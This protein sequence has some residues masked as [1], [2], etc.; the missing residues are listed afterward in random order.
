M[1]NKVVAIFARFLIDVVELPP[2]KLWQK[3]FIIE[4]VHFC[5]DDCLLRENLMNKGTEFFFK[6]AKAI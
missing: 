5:L 4:K 6:N 2:E 1:L 3:L